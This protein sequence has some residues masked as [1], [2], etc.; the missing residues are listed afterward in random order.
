M[1]MGILER[2]L[3]NFIKHNLGQFLAATA[4]VMI[5]VMF[6]ISMNTTY[7][8]LSQSQ[9]KFYKENNFA[10]YYFQMVKAPEEVVKQIEAV[11]GVRRVTGRIQKDLPIIKP[12]DE[13]ATARL[14]SYT[15]PMDNELNRITLEQGQMFAANQSST[16]A[17]V[18]LDPKF[19]PANQISWGDTVAVVV[20][21]RERF[22][23]AVGSAGSP[24]FVYPMKDAADIL[25]DPLKF[26]IF[27]LEQRQ[28]QQLLNM[29][30][31]INQVLLEFSP[32]ADQTQVAEEVKEI[33]KP[34]GLLGSY[35][36]KYQLSHAVL[37]AKLDGIR[38]MSLFMPLI[39]LAMAALIQFIILRRM[40]KTQRTQ[41]GVMKALGYSNT[42][43][44]IHYTVYAL[45]VSIL[46][47]I[48]GVI[49]GSL[50]AGSISTLFATYFDLPG[51]LHGFD[52]KTISYALLLSLGIGAVA[53]ITG[54]RGVLRIQPAEAMRAEPP[55]KAGKSW[56]EK[57][58]LVWN[59][60]S[61]EWKMTL[62]NIGRNR[63]RFIITMIGVVF[64]VGLLIMAFFYNDAVDYMMQKSFYEGETYDLTVRFNSFVSEDELLNITRL[65]GVQKAEAFMEMPVKIHFR[66]KSEDETLL[67]YP[68]DM[69]MKK[70][71]DETGRLIKVPPEGMIIN[72]RTAQKLGI[73]TGDQVEVETLLPVGPI[74]YDTVEI[75]GDTQQLFGGGSYINLEQANRIL[76]EGHVISGAMLNIETGKEAEVEHELS[77]MLGIASVISR[78]KEIQI[79]KEDMSIVTSMVSIM[80][81]FAI[82]LGF[83]IIYNSSVINFAER[84]RELATLRVM[85]F[86]MQEISSLLLKEN[87]IILL[88]GIMLGLPFGH[89]MVKSYVQSAATDQ[90]TLPVVIYPTTYLFAAI[91]GIIFIIVAHRFA[92]RAVKSLDMVATLKNTD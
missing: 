38:S 27:M 77:K 68:T 17:E 62:R 41:I 19:A 45:A 48:L 30:G 50:L 22:L 87:I 39:F 56:L 73:K 28:A 55:Q 3:W 13:R 18:L 25:P 21:G 1:V 35:P 81:F 36:R 60:F 14:V 90:F 75:V 44:M 71:Q 26:G 29:P 51:G 42:Q 46:G 84:R 76:Q 20:D 15:L 24:E 80:V 52:L 91:G 4:V 32:G 83:A 65:D 10:D 69:T 43:I 58:P 70:L 78:Q 23:T 37:Q 8:N 33:L 34:Y 31:Q 53:G 54:S 49:S 67:A 66:N 57:L 47:A 16:N 63:G 88:C 7:T 2:K 79:F 72:Q 12:N 64:A 86:T 92:L 89:L 85:G 61:P 74:H 11:N 9:A 59:S 6:Y 5:G 82:V 40:V